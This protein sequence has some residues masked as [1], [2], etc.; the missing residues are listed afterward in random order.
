MYAIIQTGGKQYKVKE[1]DILDVEKLNKKEGSTFDFKDILFTFDDKS[2]FSLG[3]PKVS[4]AS[5]KAKVLD[6]EYKAEK[7]VI[8]KYKPKKRYRRKTGHRQ[9]YTRV[10]VEK[11]TA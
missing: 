8:V 4:K 3:T 1:G 6:P 9:K 11:I 5:V 10:E 7:V 2:K